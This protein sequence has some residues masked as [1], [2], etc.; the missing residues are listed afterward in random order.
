[1]AYSQVQTDTWLSYAIKSEEYFCTVVHILFRLISPRIV[2]NKSVKYAD[3]ENL[4]Q[5]KIQLWEPQEK[6]PLQLS[7]G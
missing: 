1:M 3:P 2:G 6:Q 5:R 4:H 7:T